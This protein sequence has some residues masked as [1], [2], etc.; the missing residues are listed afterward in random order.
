M[1]ISVCSGKIGTLEIAGE[2]QIGVS[3][4]K[5]RVSSHAFAEVVLHEECIDS[6][7]SKSYGQ[8]WVHI[9]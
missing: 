7:R 4:S 1:D 5:T 2:S 9:L 8:I 6:L 3:G